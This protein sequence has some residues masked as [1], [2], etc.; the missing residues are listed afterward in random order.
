MAVS[1]CLM[2][3]TKPLK[4]LK[5][6]CQV[7][8]ASEA[9]KTTVFYAANHPVFIRAF[10]LYRH[11]DSAFQRSSFQ[12]HG[13]TPPRIIQCAYLNAKSMFPVSI[14]LGAIPLLHEFKAVHKCPFKLRLEVC[15]TSPVP[16]PLRSRVP[17]SASIVPKHPTPAQGGKRKKLN[18]GRGATALPENARFNGSIVHVA[19]P[20]A[21]IVMKYHADET[22]IDNG[23]R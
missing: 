8:D 11:E 21:Q 9:L 16:R 10:Y 12:I 6:F 3:G 7:P 4:H 5:D 23:P 1:P 14:T 17:T 18:G 19:C 15:Q 2:L 22:S 13:H 20:S